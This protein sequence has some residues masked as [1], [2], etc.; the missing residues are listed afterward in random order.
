M[1]LHSHIPAL[2]CMTTLLAATGPIHAATFRIEIDYMQN[3]NHSHRPSQ[4]V[5]DAVVQMFACQ[6]HTLIIDVDDA[7]PHYNVLQ[8]NST[9]CYNSLFD[10]GGT[11]DSFLAIKDAYFD[12]EHSDGWHYCIFSHNYKDDECNV[13]S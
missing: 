11:P 8:R 13:T 7:V 6:G 4:L 3:A 2:A 1:T 10:Y 9:F 5:V 12:H